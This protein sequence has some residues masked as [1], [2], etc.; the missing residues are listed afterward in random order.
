MAVQTLEHQP[1]GVCQHWT[2]P[3]GQA[4]TGDQETGNLVVRNIACVVS[5]YCCA[6]TVLLERAFTQTGVYSN[7]VLLKP[8]FTQSGF[9]QKE[10]SSKKVLLEKCFYSNG[11]YS[12][13]PSVSFEKNWR[14]VHRLFC[15]RRPKMIFIPRHSASL[16]CCGGC[17]CFLWRR[18]TFYDSEI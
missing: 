16:N 15:T 2:I 11:F 7:V 4:H 17:F 18:S 8:V 6:F 14:C 9:T 3:R 10:F 13:G 1:K 5:N 12:K